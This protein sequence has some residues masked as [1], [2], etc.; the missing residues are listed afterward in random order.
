MKWLPSHNEVKHA[1]W[2]LLDV[3]LK[4]VRRKALKRTVF[5]P[6][7]VTWVAKSHYCVTVAS[8]GHLLSTIVQDASGECELVSIVQCKCTKNTMTWSLWHEAWHDMTT[9]TWSHW[10][11]YGRTRCLCCLKS[12]LQLLTYLNPRIIRGVGPSYFIVQCCRNWSGRIFCC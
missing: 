5:P 6:S 3:Y 9:M 8:W 1:I 10:A 4:S 2:S 11:Q 12:L 7:L